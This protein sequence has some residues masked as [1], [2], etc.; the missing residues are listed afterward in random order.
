MSGPDSPA[1]PLKRFSSLQNRTKGLIK[2]VQAYKFWLLTKCI[3]Y[4][5]PSCSHNAS[6]SGL[7]LAFGC[8]HVLLSGPLH[9]EF[10]FSGSSYDVLSP[11]SGLCSDRPAS[12]HHLTLPTA[13][14]FSQS[15]LNSSIWHLTCAEKAISNCFLASITTISP[16]PRIV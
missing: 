11:F 14:S 16:L 13:P 2:A 3:T 9:V 10:T 5:S 4:I 8:S 7:Q 6:H 1:H 15:P 12:P